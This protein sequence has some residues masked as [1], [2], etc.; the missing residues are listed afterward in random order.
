MRCEENWQGASHGVYE[1]ERLRWRARKLGLRVVTRL[2]SQK[3]GELAEP[4]AAETAAKHDRNDLMNPLADL[5]RC[6]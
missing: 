4:R 6:G 2:P 1:R 3:N 5:D